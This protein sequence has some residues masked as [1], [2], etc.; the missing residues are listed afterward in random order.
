MGKVKKIASP[1]TS[2]QELPKPVLPTTDKVE[3]SKEAEDID[4]ALK[5]MEVKCDDK[6]SSVIVFV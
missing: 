6:F 4:E 5:A 1:P 2:K 3:S